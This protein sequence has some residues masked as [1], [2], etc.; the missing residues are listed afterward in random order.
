MYVV[1]NSVFQN[2]FLNIAK[3]LAVIPKKIK[4]GIK[5][6]TLNIDKHKL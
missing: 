6:V 2:P 5:I 1:D 3:P 4:F